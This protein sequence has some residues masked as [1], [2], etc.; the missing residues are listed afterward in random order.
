M[1]GTMTILCLYEMIATTLFC[2]DVYYTLSPPQQW[3]VPTEDVVDNQQLI[4]TGVVDNQQ[5]RSRRISLS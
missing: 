4:L 3:V 2:Y 5:L 1:F